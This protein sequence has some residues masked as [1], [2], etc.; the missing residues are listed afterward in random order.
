[1]DS[2]KL[3]T[4]GQIVIPKA[5]RDRLSLRAGQRF[6][7]VTVGNVISLVPVE[8]VRAIRGL[9]AGADTSDIRD[10]SDLA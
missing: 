6:T 10:R 7:V 5:L 3:S 4:K 9:L 1:M 8:S 2:V